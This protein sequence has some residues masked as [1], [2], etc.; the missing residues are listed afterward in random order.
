M[1]TQLKNVNNACYYNYDLLL[2]FILHAQQEKKQ[3]NRVSNYIQKYGGDLKRNYTVACTQ[4]LA[5]LYNTQ[6]NKINFIQNYKC[7]CI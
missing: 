5:S 4:I 6:R 2:I 1:Y 3:E 7:A